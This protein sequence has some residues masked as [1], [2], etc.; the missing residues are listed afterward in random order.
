MDEDY[1]QGKKVTLIGAMLNLVLTFFKLVAG[2]LGN[3]SA[4]IADALHSLSDLATDAVVLIT[5]K[6]SRRPKDMDHP[7]GHGKIETFGALA[8]GLVLAAVA[9]GMFF[10]GIH[11]LMDGRE[12]HPT[13]IALLAAAV[14]IVIK[15]FLYHYT[16]RVGR[17]TGQIALLANAWHHRSDALSSVAAFIGVGGSMM[18]VAQLDRIA[19][20]AVALFIVQA[21][22]KISWSAFL[23]L[24]DTSIDPEMI[25]RLETVIATTEGVVGL[26]EFRARRLGSKII[27][28]VHI[29]VDADT[30][31]ARGHRIA[32]RV[33]S[34]L[35][36]SEKLIMDVLVHVEPDTACSLRP[37][38]SLSFLELHN[39][40]RALVE[41]QPEVQSVVRLELAD[42]EKGVIASLEVVVKNKYAAAMPEA[43]S[44]HIR[45]VL[46]DQLGLADAKVILQTDG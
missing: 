5:M 34:R 3:S 46:I 1:K 24:I 19:S 7:Y 9:V 40:I 36:K 16:A 15:E 33:K 37:C 45:G 29:Q 12:T 21:G 30:T 22:A 41:Q 25:I 44:A 27:V 18:G 38:L 31:V 26:H 13:S 10:D 4:M 42:S 2:I 11:A 17:K 43:A 28:D 39:R 35:I 23:D 6:L 32:G 8:V 20:V 14:S